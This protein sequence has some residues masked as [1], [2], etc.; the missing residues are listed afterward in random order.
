LPPGKRFGSYHPYRRNAT[1]KRREETLALLYGC[2]PAARRRHPGYRGRDRDSPAWVSRPLPQSDGGGR[3]QGPGSGCRH[4]AEDEEAPE[5]K[6]SVQGVS[7]VRTFKAVVS[8]QKAHP[9][10]VCGHDLRDI[11]LSTEHQATLCGQNL[12]KIGACEK[13]LCFDANL[14]HQKEHI[15]EKC[16]RS[17]T[18]R[19]AFVKDYKLCVSGKPFSCGEV[20]R[21]ILATSRFFQQQATHSRE[22]SYRT[23]E[24]GASSRG[25]K[26]QRN[27]GEGTKDF[28][29]RHTLVHH[30]R[31]LARERCFMCSECGKSFSKSYSLNDHWRVHTG[32]KPYEC[33][34]CGKSFRQ[35]SS[36]IQHR[37]VHTGA[38][39]HECDECGKLFSN[40]SNLIK[41]QRIHTR[42][43]ALSTS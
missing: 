8:P 24:Y 11:L 33:G 5:Q 30:Q 15:G 20:V 19:A 34:E 37:R 4:G 40:K 38:R 25:R 2:G 17:N 3:A 22:K 39:P 35:S 21:D 12:Y 28:T 23:T 16:F 10:E 18:G 36:L 14:Q 42:V 1:E 43:K 31:D 13:Q 41:H 9:R 29:C 27:W 26:A 6:V 32:E 7:Q